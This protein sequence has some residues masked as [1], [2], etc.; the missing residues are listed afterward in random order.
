MA[1]KKKKCGDIKLTSESLDHCITG[2]NETFYSYTRNIPS[3]SGER[4]ECIEVVTSADYVEWDR[5]VKTL[6]NACCVRKSYY[7][8]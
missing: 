2:G 8:S 5:S 1:A 7:L 4:P 6:E 3:E